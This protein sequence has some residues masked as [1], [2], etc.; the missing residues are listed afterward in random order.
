MS[1]VLAAQL[2]D[3]P[4][5]GVLAVT[6]GERALAI[7][8]AQDGTLHAIEDR[9]SHAEVALSEGEVAGFEIEC[10]LHGARFDLRTGAPSGLPAT[11]PIAIYRTTVDGD[12]IF[13]DLET[14]E[15]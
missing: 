11:Q 7:V 1:A 6:V 3:M 8:R 12:N 9:C 14:K 10:W 4:A 5:N 2:S 13:V 15:N